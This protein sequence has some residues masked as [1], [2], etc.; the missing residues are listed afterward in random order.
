MTGKIEAETPTQ[1]LAKLGLTLP[2]V[3]PAAGNYAGFIL[4]GNLLAIS[5]QL[6]RRADGTL[7]TGR[8][9]DDLTTQQ[10]QDAARLSALNILAQAQTALGDLGRITHTL[11]LTGFVQATPAYTDHPKVINGASDLIATVLGAPGVHSRAAVGAVS[12]PLNSA[13]EIDALFVIA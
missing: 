2:P 13:T 10:A 1:R 8:A 9:G 4:A 7:L 5:G 6:P 12:L 11:R 3:P